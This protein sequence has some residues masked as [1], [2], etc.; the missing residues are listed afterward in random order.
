M[1][2]ASER[3]PAG[4]GRSCGSTSGQ[5]SDRRRAGTPRV[6]WWSGAGTRLAA[7]RARAERA[8]PRAAP[9]TTIAIFTSESASLLAAQCE[10]SRAYSSSSSSPGEPRRAVEDDVAL[11]AAAAARAAEEVE[12]V[13]IFAVHDGGN[14][15]G[16]VDVVEL[17]G[18]LAPI[19][20]NLPPL[21]GPARAAGSRHAAL[22][23][24]VLGRACRSAWRADVALRR[25]AAARVLE[26]PRRAGRL[27]LRAADRGARGGVRGGTG[28]LEAVADTRSGRSGR[29]WWC[30]SVG[31]LQRD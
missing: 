10:P 12:P 30:T 2:T 4:P 28:R 17:R 5:T 22:A 20:Q 6:F 14:V 21:H 29:R 15:A 1:Q 11:R 19:E 24:V 27:A 8:A 9:P 31:G 16:R 13:L 25:E 3:R 23:A 26:I 7:V 18:A